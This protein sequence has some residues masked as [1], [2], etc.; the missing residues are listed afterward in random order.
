MKR[1]ALYVRVS[2]TE[3]AKHGLSVDSQIEAL[4]QFC[5]DND[6]SVTEIYNDAGISAAKRY[7]RRPALLQLIDDCKAGKI[8]IILFTKLDRWFRSV[9][10]YYEVQTQ[11]DACHVPWR[12]I[13]EDYETETSAGIFK[14]NIMLSIA[15]AEAQRTSERIKSVNE[16]RRAKGDYIGAAP[17]GYKVVKSR[18]VLDPEKEPGMRAF[19]KHLLTTCNLMSAMRV[20]AEHGITLDKSHIYKTLRSPSYH[21]D[22]YGSPCPAYITEAEHEQII[23]NFESK[24]RMPKESNRVYLFARL[25]KCG[26]CGKSLYGIPKKTPHADGSFKYHY[27]YLCKSYE[28]T[29]IEKHN[30]QITESAMESYLLTHLDSLLD[31]HRINAEAQNKQSNRN[32][33]LK[34]KNAISAKIERLKELYIE[35]DIDKNKYQM[36]KSALENELSAI[37]IDPIPET[38]TLPDNWH[39][40]YDSLDREHKRSFWRRIIHHITITKEEGD[41]KIEIFFN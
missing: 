39:E 35:G 21:G 15:Q 14:V 2:T 12:A 34:R 11:L 36:Q 37:V 30:M 5:T 8:D 23:R 7:T 41:K 19:F 1:A 18:L 33:L 24:P 32:T 3:Q 4:K 26:C 38:I 28:N 29:A 13:W 9:A 17:V 10:D 40:V 16:Y 22:A 31:A 27:I 20:A 25:I 6:Y